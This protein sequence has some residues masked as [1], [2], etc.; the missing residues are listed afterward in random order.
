VQNMVIR[1]RAMGKKVL[2]PSL[3][4]DTTPD[5]FSPYG[6]EYS[7]RSCT[8]RKP[9]VFSVRDALGAPEKQNC[10]LSACGMAHVLEKGGEKNGADGSAPRPKFS[11]SPQFLPPLSLSRQTATEHGAAQA[12]TPLLRPWD[13]VRQAPLFP[14]LSIL[15]H[16]F[17]L[18]IPHSAGRWGGFQMWQIQKP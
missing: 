6:L 18:C 11:P 3:M 7:R 9:S 1:S 17:P 10:A 12:R 5:Q 8:T 13:P 16:G 14:S 15:S 4:A 2:G